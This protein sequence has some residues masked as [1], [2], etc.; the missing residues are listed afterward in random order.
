MK[1]KQIQL[2]TLTLISRATGLSYSLV[3]KVSTG[4]RKHELIEELLSLAH[5]DRKAFAARIEEERNISSKL[6][7]GVSLKQ[8]I[9]Q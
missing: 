3:S 6:Y 4:A 5:N 2:G 1:K 8:A 7:G 9:N